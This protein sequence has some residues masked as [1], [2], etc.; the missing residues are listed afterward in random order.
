[1]YLLNVSEID[2]AYERIQSLIIK[3]P[4]IINETINEITGA[5]VYFK[6]EN[7]Q[8]TGSFKI[9]GAINK[10]SQLSNDDKNR[11]IVA[12]SS[13]NHAQAVAYASKIYNTHATIVMPKNAP[14][15][16]IKNTKN[17]GAKVVLYDEA[18]TTREKL[19]FENC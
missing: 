13:G 17:F 18:T 1:M 11:G 4:L 9:R 7:L 10:I 14:L 6:L 2:N 5:N 19:A 8:I 16:K 3:T 15:I 12:Y